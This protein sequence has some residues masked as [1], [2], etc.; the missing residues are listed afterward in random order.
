MLGFEGYIPA[1][2]LL[3]EQLFP[4]G[5]KS[6]VFK[7]ASELG[8]VDNDPKIANRNYEILN[9]YLNSEPRRVI[10]LDGGK[11]WIS[12]KLTI[13][14]PYTAI[15][16][17]NRGKSRDISCI[18]GNF[19]DTIIEINIPAGANGIYLE[20]ISIDGNN[21][22]TCGID[23]GNNN[24]NDN[25]FNGIHIANING[26]GFKIGENNYTSNY[27]RISTNNCQIGLQMESAGN[28]QSVFRDCQFL[29]NQYAGIIGTD[30]NSKEGLRCILF[31]N[32][33][34]TSSGTPLKILKTSYNIV[35]NR[36][37]I[38]K[39]TFSE[40]SHCLIELG[41]NNVFAR[42]I[43]FISPI[44]QC[45]SKA[46][47]VIKWIQ[48]ENII[49]PTEVR[50]VSVLSG[51]I[52][53]TNAIN[54]TKTSILLNGGY[55]NTSTA[56]IGKSISDLFML[57]IGDS[58]HLNPAIK[59]KISIDADATPAAPGNAVFIDGQRR[60]EA[61]PRIRLAESGLH[62]GNGNNPTDIL[63]YRH[64]SK[65]A[66]LGKDQ[67]FILNTGAWNSGH[68]IL[69]SYHIWVDSNGKLRIKNGAPTSDI[70]GE[71]VGAQQ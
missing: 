57:Y 8:L 21:V 6:R 23:V 20:N 69:G 65:T 2:I 41:S 56:V 43:T 34:F 24:F 28:Q 10:F 29:G 15:I 63:F 4:Q 14:Q 60:S 17:N 36:P 71:V 66:G 50:V 12:Q 11:Y 70:D 30:D 45:N 27:Y 62:M 31:D 46:E 48:G 22:A 35:F 7:T 33:D 40:P 51:F 59:G 38:E 25:L 68:L 16:G 58:Y 53:A 52:D 9:K 32:C 55:I 64:S 39:N 18:A 67:N 13:T 37:W 44:F 61:H 47:Y 49:F 54:T 26:V 19:P 1:Q 42:G 5:D 3:P